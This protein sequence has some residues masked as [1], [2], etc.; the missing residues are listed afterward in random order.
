MAT[1]PDVQRMA[2]PAAKKLMRQAGFKTKVQPV[3]VKRNGVGYVIYSNPGV[4]T[5]APQGSTVILYVV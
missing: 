2:L 1:V 5:E 4:R 3:G